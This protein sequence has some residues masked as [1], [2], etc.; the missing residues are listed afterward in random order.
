MASLEESFGV[1]AALPEVSV[2]AQYL[3]CTDL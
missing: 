3:L 1:F 2:H